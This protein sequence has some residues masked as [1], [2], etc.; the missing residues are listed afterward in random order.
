ML[1]SEQPQPACSL[2]PPGTQPTS[3]RYCT[4]APLLLS[5]LYCITPSQSYY[6]ISTYYSFAKLLSRL[7][8]LLAYLNSD[9]L[10]NNPQEY[11]TADEFHS[12]TNPPEG[13]LATANNHIQSPDGPN[14]ATFSGL[15][16]RVDR[17]GF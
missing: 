7:Y 13:F 17:C 5:H 11:L 8:V 12:V 4:V 6:H 14:V 16:N 1:R 2:F 10:I 9:F 3:G 15:D